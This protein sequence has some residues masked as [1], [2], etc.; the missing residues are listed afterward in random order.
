MNPSPEPDELPD[1]VLVIRALAAEDP[2]G[3]H[4]FR[5]TWG[6]D[7]EPASHAAR[8]AEEVHRLVDA[9]LAGISSA[10]E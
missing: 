4:L 8:A 10:A 1:S 2:Q 7:G 5:V 9:W 3:G 6:R